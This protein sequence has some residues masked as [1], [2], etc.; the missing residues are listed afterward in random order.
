MR[1]LTNDIAYSAVANFFW[2][3]ASSLSLIRGWLKRKFCH[4]GFYIHTHGKSCYVFLQ[5][6]NLIVPISMYLFCYFNIGPPINMYIVISI[7]A[8]KFVATRPVLP[9]FRF[10]SMLR[11]Y[12]IRFYRI[13]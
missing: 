10:Y 2:F 3:A 13:D 1:V 7:E 6:A 12:R 8:T 5:L 9:L 11:F 4:I